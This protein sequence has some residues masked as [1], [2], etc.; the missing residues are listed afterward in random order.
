MTEENTP[1]KILAQKLNRVIV[2]IKPEQ[3][4]SLAEELI[5]RLEFSGYAVEYR[6][7]PE[8]PILMG[9]GKEEAA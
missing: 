8:E 7:L 5:R 6:G 9:F 3:A 1:A 2:Q 4:M